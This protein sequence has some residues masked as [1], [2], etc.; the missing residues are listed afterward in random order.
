M[1]PIINYLKGFDL[2]SIFIDDQVFKDDDPQKKREL[3]NK[4]LEQI[5]IEEDNNTSEVV[6]TF[7][8]PINDIIKF[9]LENNEFVEQVYDSLKLKNEINKYENDDNNLELDNEDKDLDNED[10]DLDNEDTDLDL[11]NEDKD[12]DKEDKE[13]KDLDNQD[14]YIDL[15]GEDP[16]SFLKYPNKLELINKSKESLLNHIKIATKLNDMLDKIYE[17]DELICDYSR[18]IFVSKF[19]LIDMENEGALYE[20]SEQIDLINGEE[21]DIESEMLE[22]MEIIEEYSYSDKKNKINIDVDSITGK[23]EKLKEREINTSD[24]HLRQ[25][26]S[27]VQYSGGCACGSCRPSKIVSI[28]PLLSYDRRFFPA[29]NPINSRMSTEIWAYPK[30]TEELSIQDF[31]K[32]FLIKNKEET[33]LKNEVKTDTKETI[34]VSNTIE[35]MIDELDTQIQINKD[36][37]STITDSVADT[38]LEKETELI[39][40]DNEL[41]CPISFE[42]IKELAMTCYG[43]IYEKEEIE[44][45]LSGH[46]TD[47]LSGRFMFTKKLITKGIDPNNIKYWQKKIRENMQILYNYPVEL[48][49]PETKVNEVNVI[50]QKIRSFDESNQEIWKEYTKDKLSYFRNPSNYKSEFNRK[51]YIYRDN[52]LKRIPDTGTGFEYID[53]SADYFTKF[54]HVGQSF[55]STSFNGADLSNNVF[56]QC[57]FSRCTFIGA[58]LSA[59]IFHGCSFLGEEVNFANAFSTDETQFIDC[60]VEDIGDWTS[61]KIQEKVKQCLKRR[62]LN[63]PFIV[64][65]FDE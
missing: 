37:I 62:L 17:D 21:C 12:E 44:A 13:D 65:S 26:F 59:T 8:F 48:L 54:Q 45:W 57:Q 42:P 20:I 5:K 43:Q 28:D 9:M 51:Q 14:E 22:L 60:N 23:K 53:L 35:E 38:I 16:F 50:K 18:E 27:E 32:K 46:D 7:K 15:E 47:P 19:N 34:T 30:Y 52:S 4:F 49:Y 55:K 25:L 36:D 56:V 31:A 61:W 24:N 6:D 11:D 10:K 41:I 64:L 2:N 40:E 58:N 63:G 1:N 29:P 39:M 33:K 3:I